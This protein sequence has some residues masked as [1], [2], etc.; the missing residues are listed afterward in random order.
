MRMQRVPVILML[1]LLGACAA[2]S[3]KPVEYLDDRTAMTVGVLKEPLEFVPVFHQEGMHVLGKLGKRLSFAYL[4]PIEWDR[5]GT[6]AYGLW[7]HVAPSAEHMVGDIRAPAAITLTLDDAT[8]TLVPMDAPQL[9]K[10]AYEPVA[11][12]GQTAYYILNVDMLKHMAASQKLEMQ[13]AAPDAGSIAF[14]P[15]GDT[16][17]ALTGFMKARGLTGD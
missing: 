13:V 6:L 16:R 2:E 12:W 8:L 10:S 3:S 17:A 1:A 15:T 14:S 11:S 4:G 7:L 9:G 5:S